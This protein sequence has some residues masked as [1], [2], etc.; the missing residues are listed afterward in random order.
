MFIKFKKEEINN[1][2][3]KTHVSGF[4][5]T[6]NERARAMG[7]DNVGV[8]DI[9]FPSFLNV[10]KQLGVE[11]SLGGWIDFH[12]KKY[13]KSLDTSKAKL[14][15]K[16]EEMLLI[17]NDI[18]DETIEN[19]I[20]DLLYYKTF[21]GKMIEFKIYEAFFNEGYNVIYERDK[22]KNNSIDII[23]DGVNYQIKPV[24]TRLDT[25][26]LYSE[27]GINYIYYKIK[28]EGIE[29]ML[30]DALKK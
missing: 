10:C 9:D 13:P 28:K 22:I 2:S 5:N 26:K 3:F 25:H 16:V 4:L 23:I 27:Q 30:P 6:A 21:R 7:K 29:I 17:L 15:S 14:K 12:K 20:I 18:D 19:Y 8:I 1:Y 24:S 11:P